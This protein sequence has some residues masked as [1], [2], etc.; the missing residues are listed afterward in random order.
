[1]VYRYVNML[2][3]PLLHATVE[4]LHLQLGL[5]WQQHQDYRQ[6]QVDT[7]KGLTAL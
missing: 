4:R 3:R 5:A 2:L 6:L 1:M 7:E